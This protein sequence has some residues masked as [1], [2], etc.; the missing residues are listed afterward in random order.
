MTTDLDG[1]APARTYVH[2]SNHGGAT[3]VDVDEHFWETLGRRE[4]LQDG[5]MLGLLQLQAGE[6]HS[7]RHPS[8]DELLI[9]LSGAVDV[10]FEHVDGERVAA[11]RGFRACVIPCGVWHRLRVHA[12]SEI[13]FITPGKGTDVRAPCGHTP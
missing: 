13:L 9:L 4:D 1:F 10:V 6:D 3:T 12:P 8:G 5:R 7:E 2:L 11:L